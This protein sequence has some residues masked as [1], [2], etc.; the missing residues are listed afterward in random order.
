[1][2]YALYLSVTQEFYTYW[3]VPSSGRGKKRGI[4]IKFPSS[5]ICD[6]NTETRA[7]F[8]REGRVRKVPETNLVFAEFFEDVRLQ[9]LVLVDGADD[10]HLHHF[11]LLGI[12]V[13]V[14]LIL[15]QGVQVAQVLD[16]DF[17]AEQLPG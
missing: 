15:R 13:G 17:L 2:H 12:L 5:A 1:M 8:G 3:L 7:M 9:R 10:D 11:R 16:Q 14:V 4:I 6:S